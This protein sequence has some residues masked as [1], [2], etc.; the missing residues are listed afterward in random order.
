MDVFKPTAW[1]CLWLFCCLSEQS[2]QQ[3][4]TF[5]SITVTW[6]LSC[7]CAHTDST[8]CRRFTLLS[9]HSAVPAVA[10]LWTAA[11]CRVVTVGSAG[12]WDSRNTDH[13]SLSKLQGWICPMT[14]KDILGFYL[15]YFIVYYSSINNHLHLTFLHH[16]FITYIQSACRTWENTTMTLF[17]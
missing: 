17:L 15:W 7:A 1:T 2:L 11:R 12:M 16:L 9:L 8:L 10:A 3:S 4:Q 5:T 13:G 14:G 6:L